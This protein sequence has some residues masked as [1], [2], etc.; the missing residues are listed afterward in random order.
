MKKSDVTYIVGATFVAFTNL[1]YCC[2]MWFHIKLPRYYPRL[3]TWKWFS[4]IE[5]EPSQGWYGM[6]AFAFL[7][8]GIVALTVYFILK[9]T[10]KAETSLKPKQTRMLGVAA[11]LI[12]IICM[13]Y[14]L[15]YEFGRWGVFASM[16][17]Q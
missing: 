4:K 3:R 5:G 7:A 9:R 2:T 17:L 15:F 1:F 8:G 12:A 10:V 16:G 6:Q 13:G 14:M 11:I